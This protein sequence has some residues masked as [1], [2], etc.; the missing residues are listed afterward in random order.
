M[1][2]I[3]EY[4]DRVKQLNPEINVRE[5]TLQDGDKFVS[6]FNA[7]YARKTNIN[8]FTWQF[9]ESGYPYHYQPKAVF[10]SPLFFK[11]YLLLKRTREYS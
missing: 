4:V 8:Y 11:K 10:S 3:Q 2:D 7:Y 5:A 1:H 6:L 9:F